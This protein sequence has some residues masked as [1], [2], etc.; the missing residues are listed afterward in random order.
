[1]ILPF[2]YDYDALSQSHSAVSGV[3]LAVLEAINPN[4]EPLETRLEAILFLLFVLGIFAAAVYYDKKRKA[5]GVTVK[6]NRW[7]GLFIW[8]CISFVMIV[9]I[10]FLT[11]GKG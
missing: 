2:G 1:M 7:R 6:R 11:N 8:I 3:L 10:S 4:R 9:I 5:A